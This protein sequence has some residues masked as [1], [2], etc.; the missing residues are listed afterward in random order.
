MCF[1]RR[2][3]IWIR[4]RLTGAFSWQLNYVEWLAC[5]IRMAVV[6]YG[7]VYGS[8]PDEALERLTDDMM[9]NDAVALK[10]KVC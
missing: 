10:N 4:L 9:L 2:D 1:A 6:G 7:T 3:I 5:L 8:S